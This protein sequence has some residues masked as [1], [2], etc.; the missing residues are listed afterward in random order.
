MD[1]SILLVT[2]WSKLELEKVEDLKLY[3]ESVSFN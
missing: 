1:I 3:D 2:I